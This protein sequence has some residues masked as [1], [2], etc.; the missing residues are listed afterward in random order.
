MAVVLGVLLCAPLAL[1]VP[2]LDRV[3]RSRGA[4]TAR[5]GHALQAQTMADRT[6]TLWR[7]ADRSGLSGSQVRA[8]QRVTVLETQGDMLRV[9]TEDGDDGWVSRMQVDA[10]DYSVAPK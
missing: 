3:S 1:L 10:W 6:M 7:S 4:P 8:G 2:T 5:I 9:W